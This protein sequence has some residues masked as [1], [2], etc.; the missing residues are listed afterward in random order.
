[1]TVDNE[2][3]WALLGVT[4]FAAIVIVWAVLVMR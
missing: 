3:L 4:L 2:D 1:M